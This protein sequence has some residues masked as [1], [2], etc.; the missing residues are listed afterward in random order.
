MAVETSALEHLLVSGD[1]RQTVKEVCKFTVKYCHLATV[2]HI[3][4]T[5]KISLSE[6]H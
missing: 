6:L 1:Q 5:N 2:K 4:S 3:E